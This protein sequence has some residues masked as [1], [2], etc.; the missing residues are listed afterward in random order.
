MG[1]WHNLLKSKHCYFFNIALPWMKPSRWWCSRYL[2][3]P[4]TQNLFTKFFLGFSLTHSF[5]WYL[6]TCPNGLAKSFFCH[7][8]SFSNGFTQ[9][10]NPPNGQNLLR[11]VKVLCPCSLVHSY[12]DSWISSDLT[13]KLNRFSFSDPKIVKFALNW[14]LVIFKNIMDYQEIASL[15]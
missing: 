14:G 12:S 11:M 2:R 5:A 4:G 15:N 3:N 13:I 10:L 9:I 8:C 7:N 6:W 1:S